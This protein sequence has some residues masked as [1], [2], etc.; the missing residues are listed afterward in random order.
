MRFVSN[1]PARDPLT[2][3]QLAQYY[4]L[5]TNLMWPMARLSAHISVP[6]FRRQILNKEVAHPEAVA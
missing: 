1:M 2:T 6:F 4:F 5:Y 3:Q